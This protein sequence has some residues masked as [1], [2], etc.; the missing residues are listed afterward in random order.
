MKY[1]NKNKNSLYQFYSLIKRPENYPDLY[2][3]NKNQNRAA[4]NLKSGKK[5][6][7][8]VSQVL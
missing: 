6:I 1:I 5:S 2:L 8:L 4:S 3:N 7:V